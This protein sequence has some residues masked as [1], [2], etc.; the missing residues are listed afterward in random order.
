ML[1]EEELISPLCD[2]SGVHASVYSDCVSIKHNTVLKKFLIEKSY[3]EAAVR[4]LLVFTPNCFSDR[5][6]RTFLSP[7][8]LSNIFNR[9]KK[10]VEV[11]RRKAFVA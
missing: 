8:V 7:W 2:R 6:Y 9:G 4:Y 11:R 3:K 1:T 10:I 5:R